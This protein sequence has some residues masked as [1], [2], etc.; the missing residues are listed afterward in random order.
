MNDQETLLDLEVDDFAE[1]EINE[2][3][4]WSKLLAILIFSVIGLGFCVF[5]FAWDKIVYAFTT[6]LPQD[7]TRALVSVLLVAFILICVVVGLMMFFLIRGGNRVRNGLRIKDQQQF[8][9]GLNDLKIYFIFMGVISILSLL[10]N[11]MSF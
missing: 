11:L 5:I 2:T 10:V 9:N 6:E 1:K 8:N 7:E 4:R 3:A